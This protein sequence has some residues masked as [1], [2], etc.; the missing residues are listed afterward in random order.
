VQP[1]E[2]TCSPPASS[3]GLTRASSTQLHSN[4]LNFSWG[5]REV[6]MAHCR[7]VCHMLSLVLVNLDQE[8][9]DG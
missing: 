9:S 7:L 1:G 8:K 3:P 2:G 6:G 5:H 4:G